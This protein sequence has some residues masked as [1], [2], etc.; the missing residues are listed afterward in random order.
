MLD[1]TLLLAIMAMMIFGLGFKLGRQAENQRNNDLPEENDGSS[2]YF[3]GLSFLLADEPDKAIEAFIE[4]VRVNSDTVE[5]YL[6]LGN[7]FRA[8]GEVG[9]AIRIHQ[10]IIARPQLSP[11]MQVAALFALAEDY[12]QGGFLDRA[13]AAYRRVLDKDASHTQALSGLLALHENEGRWDEALFVLKRLAA[14]SGKTDLR[15]EAHLW[16][17]QGQEWLHSC[18][19]A[20]SEKERAD[21]E[22]R[23]VGAFYSAIRIFPGCVEA[24]RLLGERFLSRGEADKVITLLGSLKKERPSHFFLLFD[25]LQDAYSA[26]NDDAGFKKCMQEAI[27]APSSPQLLIR[28]SRFLKESGQKKEADAVLRDGLKKHPG[29]AELASLRLRLL[30]EQG[31]YADATLTAQAYL[32]QLTLKQPLF[33]CSQ[34]GFKA[35]EIYWK[36]PQCHHWDTMIPS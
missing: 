23:A 10:T 33:Q 30:S 5:I 31:R 4:V 2:H 26:A 17:K 6:S 3:R 9:R 35:R 36:C 12:R 8:R 18:R 20:E 19:H 21:L 13:V 15:R 22:E 32:D 14:V 27:E 1:W 28:W 34:C 25:L 24:R 29:S 7:L 16:I 11:E